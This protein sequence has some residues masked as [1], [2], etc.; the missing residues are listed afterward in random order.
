MIAQT[1]QVHAG[2]YYVSAVGIANIA[3]SSTASFYI[4]TA[5]QK[6]A[7]HNYSSVR[8]GS[9]SNLDVFTVNEGDSF[10]IWCYTNGSVLVSG[11]PVITAVLINVPN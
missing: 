5:N 6:P 8:G 3:N 2:T 9:F 10:E 4:T 11:P 7:T 1:A